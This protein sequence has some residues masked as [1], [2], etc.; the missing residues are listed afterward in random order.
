MSVDRAWELMARKLAG[1]ASEAELEELDRLLKVNP[2]LHFPMQT[3][4]DLWQQKAVADPG[5]LEQAFSKHLRRMEEQGISFAANSTEAEE[6]ATF[7]MSDS[8]RRNKPWKYIA[9]AAS[10]LLVGSIIWYYSRPAIAEQ[11]TGLANS[12]KDPSSEIVTKNGSRTRITL[13]DGSTVWLNAGSKLNYDKSFGLKLRE[14]SLTGEA[15]FDVV[16]NPDQP[17]IIHTNRIDIK[18]LGTQFNVKSYPGEKTTEA[19][20]VKGS[21][22]VD[23]HSEQSGKIILKPNQKIIVGEDSAADGSAKAGVAKLQEPIVSVRQ[24]T[25]DEKDGTAVETAWVENKLAFVEE[26]FADVALKMERWYGVNISFSNP[27]LAKVSLTGSFANESIKEA[28]HALSVATP[29]SYQFTDAKTIV[30]GK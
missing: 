29:F 10:L 22:Q 28:L 19:A 2:G 11:H 6:P 20:L 18:V 17:F 1:E 14:V 9:A 26:P 25:I 8:S 24:M 27:K 16:K 5:E 12:R 7:R 13:P 15:F 3:L 21:I 30:I 4:T 23:L